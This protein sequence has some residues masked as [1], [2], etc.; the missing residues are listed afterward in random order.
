MSIKSQLNNK[1]FQGRTHLIYCQAKPS[2]K[3]RVYIVHRID[4]LESIL[5]QRT[6]LIEV[7]K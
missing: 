3:L 5:F 6:S 7:F 1:E 4:Q 2:S